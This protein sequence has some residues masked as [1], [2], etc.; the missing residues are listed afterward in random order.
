MWLHLFYQVLEAQQKQRTLP[1]VEWSPRYRQRLPIAR[2]LPAG[3]YICLSVAL[4]WAAWFSLLK[5]PALPGPGSTPCCLFQSADS[6]S[7]AQGT[8]PVQSSLSLPMH[9][10]HESLATACCC[11]C[12]CCSHCSCLL[13]SAGLD[14][15]IHLYSFIT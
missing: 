6:G 4:S 14:C 11:H 15:F 5:S 8:P 9:I 2:C 1:F 10:P 3:K 13:K 12:W 7:V